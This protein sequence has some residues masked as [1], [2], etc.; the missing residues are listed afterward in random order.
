[1]IDVID[2]VPAKPNRILITPEDGS[3]SFYATWERADEPI[4]AGTPVNRILFDSIQEASEWG[5]AHAELDDIEICAMQVITGADWTPITFNKP[6]TGVPRVFVQ[7]IDSNSC[8]ASIRNVTD[9]GCE[10][11]TAMISS[12]SVTTGKK[13]FM[14]GYGG[15]TSYYGDI[16]YVAS[17]TQS[18]ANV[19]KAVNIIAIY[20]G[21]TNP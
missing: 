7:I 12:L 20:D 21:G 19:S 11:L 14:T 16:D 18:T 17:V 5:E 1:M 8:F 2:R 13:Q 6:F 10:V 9:K 4:E 15:G 3:P